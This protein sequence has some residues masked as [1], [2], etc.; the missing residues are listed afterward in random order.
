MLYTT[1]T[2]S[3]FLTTLYIIFVPI[4][5][6]LFFKVKIDSKVYVTVAIAVIGAFLLMGGHLDSMNKGD[7]VTLSC[8]VVG[9]LHIIYLGKVSR[10]V[11][12]V[13]R[14]NNWQTFFCWILVLPFLALQDGWQFGKASGLAWAG[15]LFLGVG[16]SAIAFIFQIR[17]QRI[18][19][20]TTSS[21]IFLL[22]SPFAFAFGF[23]LLQERLLPIQWAGALIILTSS[24][25]TILW[26][27]SSHSKKQTQ[28]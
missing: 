26:D 17:G 21:M 24:G 13:V 27:S 8:A 20:D 22:E 7:L 5:N 25:L 11:K 14:F 16:S 10:F 4:L 6:H 2:N 28:Q 1:A 19:S 18:L 3:G 15:V 12:D 23:L 9:A